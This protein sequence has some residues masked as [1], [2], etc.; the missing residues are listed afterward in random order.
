ML[1]TIYIFISLFVKVPGP[2]PSFICKQLKINT[3]TLKFTF[4]FI[5]GINNTFVYISSFK[6]HL[7]SFYFETSCVLIVLSE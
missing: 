2:S 1:R 4:L 5:F 6:V 7:F 3:C